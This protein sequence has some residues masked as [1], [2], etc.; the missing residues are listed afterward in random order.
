MK[1]QELLKFKSDYLYTKDVKNKDT[2]IMR[3]INDKLNIL[4]E[5]EKNNQRRKTKFDIIENNIIEDLINNIKF[6][7]KKYENNELK[8]IRDL[9]KD[10]IGV[11]LLVTN[12]KYYSHIE[13]THYNTSINNNKNINIEDIEKDLKK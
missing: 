6:Q 7:I 2:F 1:Y 10:N 5:E 9:Y 12:S 4:V 13:V 8:N 11:I 3:K